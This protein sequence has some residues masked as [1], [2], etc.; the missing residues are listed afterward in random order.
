VA[1]PLSGIPIEVVFEKEKLWLNT[2]STKTKTIISEIANDRI[3]RRSFICF[4]QF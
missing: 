2:E 3:T 1:A 4:L